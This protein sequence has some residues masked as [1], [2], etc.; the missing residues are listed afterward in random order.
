MEEKTV[1]ITVQE[2]HELLRK[3]ERIAAVERLCARSSYVCVDDVKHVL[4]I[5]EPVTK[6]ENENA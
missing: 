2:Y 6:G 4:D 3:A 5:K 1:E